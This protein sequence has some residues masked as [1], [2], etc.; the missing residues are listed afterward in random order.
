VL[1]LLIRSDL[2]AHLVPRRLL[3]RNYPATARAAEEPETV[4]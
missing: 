3:D 1:T 2:T 4:T